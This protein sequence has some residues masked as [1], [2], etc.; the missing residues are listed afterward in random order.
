M[1]SFNLDR[2]E[3]GQLL[4]RDPY[5]FR[6]KPTPC[7]RH[8]RINVTLIMS[9]LVAAIVGYSTSFAL[10][11]AEFYAEHSKVCWIIVCC[12]LVVP[13]FIYYLAYLAPY[14][15]KDSFWY[16]VTATLI[17]VSILSGVILGQTNFV[18]NVQPVK[19]SSDMYS[20][21]K[22]DPSQYDAG[23]K[24]LDAGSIEFLEGAHV[25]TSRGAG[26]RAGDTYCVAPIVMEGVEEKFEKYFGYLARC[27]GKFCI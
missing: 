2:A 16:H 9:N 6:G 21:S 22:I 18:S 1:S 14:R 27:E 25:D 15:R 26:F 17:L 20:Y 13:F 7:R 24:Y 8:R 11:S 23:T 4:G 19:H 5:N 10:L 12:M 3:G